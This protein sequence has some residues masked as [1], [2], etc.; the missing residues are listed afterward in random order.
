MPELSEAYSS[1]LELVFVL[2]IHNLGRKVN[3]LLEEKREQVV[4]AAYP[5]P[6]LRCWRWKLF[7]IFVGECVQ[8]KAG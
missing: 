4:I 5:C 8:L 2:N 3:L 7:A 6:I 1:A